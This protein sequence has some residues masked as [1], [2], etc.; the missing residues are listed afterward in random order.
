MRIL[1]K[2]RF[3]V[4]IL[5]LYFIIPCSAFAEISSEL[6]SAIDNAKAHATSPTASWIPTAAS[7][8]T[9]AN[10]SLKY[11]N[12]GLIVRSATKSA[13]WG[14]TAK[15]VGQTYTT[16]GTKGS[17]ADWVTTGNDFTNFYDNKGNS[18][19]NTDL[20]KV[21]ERGLGM[22]NTGTHDVI[23]EYIVNPGGVVLLNNVLM[24]ATKNPILS[25]FSTEVSKYGVPAPFPDISL[26]GMTDAAAYSTFQSYYNY[27]NGVAYNSSNNMP[28]T[29]LGYTYFW[30]NGDDT[31]AKIQGMSEFVVMAATDVTVYGVYT[32]ASYIYTKNAGQYGNG[33]ASFN[34]TGP[35]DS[36]WAGHRF[37][38]NT[39]SSAAGTNTI[40]NSG[41][42]SGGQGILIWSLNYDVTNSGTIS[43]ST[44]DKCGLSNT[45]D[46]A[47]LFKG[48]T[49]TYS[50]A[51]PDG[52]NS[53][54]NTGTVSSPGIAVKVESGNTAISNTGGTISGGTYAIQ[55]GSGA[56]SVN[57][58]SG[59]MNGNV[60]L[61]SGTND[62]KA[63]DT[64]GATLG[65]T[66]DRDMDTSPII[67]NITTATFTD[68]RVTAAFTIGGTKNVKDGETFS[69]IN[70]A[71]SISAD[72]SKI[73]VQADNSHPMVASYALSKIGNE[74]LVTTARNN[75]YYRDNCGNASL[76]AVL[77]NLANTATN[78][79]MMTVIGA[80]DG[81][82]SA[83]SANQLEPIA[84]NSV[85]QTNY[86]TMN[87]FIN[88]ILSRFDNVAQIQ[89]RGS[90]GAITGAT[91]DTTGVWTQG[92]DTYLHEDPRGSSNGYNANVWGVSL[93]FDT[94]LLN[95][96][97]VGLSG[98]YAKDNIRTKD[99]SGR[100]DIDSY[101]V[102]LYGSHAK[103]AYYLDLVASFAYNVYNS[104]RH[105]AFGDIDRNP[106]ADYG[107][108]QYSG[109]IE[110]GYTFKNKDVTLTPLASLQY[111][112]LHINGYTEE[113]GGSIDLS[114]SGQDYDLLQTGLGAKLAYKVTSERCTIIPD[115]HFR[116][117]YDFIGDRQQAT[118]T[119]TGGG[120]SFV[121][122]GF[123]PAQ[124]SYNFGTKLIIMAAKNVTLT[125]NYD[126]EL[127]EDFYSHAGYL[128]VRY[129][130]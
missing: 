51:P 14:Y 8:I 128:N 122:N 59:T 40:D 92:F 49:T 35:C 129:D 130:F 95:N 78:A 12:S 105:V 2:S 25:S 79:D 64:A 81:S 65:L 74:L 91:L 16:Y 69:I 10:A 108:Q 39:K 97:I 102:S 85:P 4:V 11:V 22:N 106:T 60:D 83:A 104:S 19:T 114:V 103:D 20:I 58:H 80:L 96:S 5:I 50:A 1:R 67:A 32:T 6:Q 123:D 88:N 84:D 17:S 87:Q 120:A 110:S 121:T 113:D 36:V 21:V 15:A 61:G 126:F 45:S 117:F 47:I 3:T 99:S 33:Y 125:A 107:G 86:D 57:I 112:H 70:P 9:T 94:P 44:S 93:G 75:D 31:I 13:F 72:T 42:I 41:T 43:G 27:W 111:S 46:I 55:T 63:G 119:F 34:I 37:Q 89:T 77:D 115:L 56:D 26:T 101:E 100:S 109:Y 52:S 71:T 118:S 82:G 116:W 90:T 29:Q 24:R 48:D 54:T 7:M 23:L 76:G 53:L 66:L 62:F 28:W 30:G 38:T 124:S 68:N 98:G 73:S 18:V 127:K